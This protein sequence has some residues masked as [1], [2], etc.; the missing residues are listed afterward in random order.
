MDFEE[1]GSFGDL[2]ARYRTQARKSQQQLAD[3][4]AVH[5]STVVK[6]EQKG[7]LPKDRARVDELARCLRLTEP[8]RD[9]LLRAALL[10]T[11][12]PTWNLPYPRNPFFT[13]R[14]QELTQLHALLQHRGTAVVGQMQSI[15]GLGGMGKT[16]LAVEYAY[17]HHSEYRYV[18]WARAESR[19]SLNSSYSEIAHLL[20]LPEKGSEEPEKVIQATKRWLQRQRSWL[21]ILDNADRPDLPPDFLPPT[22]GGHLL[23]TTRAAEVS[24]H[25]AGLAH[26][27]VVK[28][29]SDEQGA[30]F[31]LRRSGLLALDATL[32]QAETRSQQLAM[33]IAH[34]LGGLPL[35]L[36]QAGAYLYT[37]G[38]SLSTYQQIY[39]QRRSQLL[40][41]R[42]RAD[43]PE[44]VATTWTISFRAVEQHNPAAADLL[45]LCAFLAPDAIPEELLSE[46]AKELSGMLAPLAADPYLLDQAITALRAYSLI[47]RDPQAQT[48][49]VHR[50]VQVVL[51]DSLPAETQPQWMQ[52]AVQAVEAAYPGPEFAHWPLL[53]RWL[54][55]ALVCATWIEHASLVM[56]EAS[57]LLNQAGVFLKEQGRYREAELLYQR[58]LAI[59]EQ[60]VGAS[61]PITASVLNNLAELYREQGMYRE[62]EPFYQR[63]LAIREQQLGASHPDTA[64]SL[65]NL[66]LLYQAQRKDAEAESLYQRALAIYEQELGT[67]HPDTA[68]CLHNLAELYRAQGKY[69]AAEPFYQRALAIWEQ[70]LGANHPHTASSLNNLAELYRIQGKYAAAEPLYLRALAIVERELGAEHPSTAVILNNLALLY[71]M[72]KKY[73]EAEPLYLR[74]LSIQ[75]QQSGVNHPNT[76]NSLN[77]L[78]VLYK[79]QKR[80]EEAE[81]L[82]QRALS[83]REELLGASHPDTAR[84]LHNLALFY[85]AQ[86]KEEQA[87][88]LHQRALVI[89][90]TLLGQNHPTTQSMHGNLQ[91]MGGEEKAKEPKEGS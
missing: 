27:L 77:N 36:D 87:E 45:R 61:H 51:R 66:A 39:R 54:P 86:G 59:R 3:C 47:D 68:T 7:S 82:Y 10:D 72:Q 23:I 43:Y 52:R 20:N 12:S 81:P 78:A 31:L 40:G 30:L 14:D 90:E 79:Q 50:L 37:T 4:L 58:S 26:P 89:Y 1:E 84:S 25:L 57:R 6:W 2:L 38:S 42:R 73:N 83:I 88:P 65:N 19:E 80:Y 5:R 70:E 24:A 55:H 64:T 75:E 63:A 85:R 11:A 69:T 91:A 8:Q 41:E 15:S 74:A 13:G 67:G 60:M 29:F 16:Q 53:E 22:V 62:A 46:G 49:T 71:H 18:L 21:L 33:E 9:A 32:D 44:S 35:A 76:A 17:R 56:P 34:E 48:L 28:T